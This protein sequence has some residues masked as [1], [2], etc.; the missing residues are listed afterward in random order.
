MLGYCT[1]RMQ[2]IKMLHVIAAYKL[3]WSCYKSV[4]NSLLHRSEWNKVYIYIMLLLHILIVLHSKL[5]L[6]LLAWIVCEFGLS[7]A[8]VPVYSDLYGI[9][10]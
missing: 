8:V 4:M 7:Y 6:S 2:D 5:W 9:V 10:K 3:P 1:V